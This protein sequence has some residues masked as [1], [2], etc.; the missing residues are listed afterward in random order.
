MGL[1]SHAC[2]YVDE[3]QNT[4]G[5]SADFFEGSVLL[6]SVTRM[7]F[8]PWSLDLDGRKTATVWTI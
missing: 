6:G 5:K 4:G 3:T 2:W 8:V 1:Y 7:V